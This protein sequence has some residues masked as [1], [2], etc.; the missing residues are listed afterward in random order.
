MWLAQ[1]ASLPLEVRHR[2]RHA[3]AAGTMC[4][5][6]SVFV[7]MCERTLQAELEFTR[8][9]IRKNFSNFSAWHCRCVALTRHGALSPDVLSRGAFRGCGL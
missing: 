6:L 7:C 3:L 2:A 1:R 9:L 5:C 4:V 8:A